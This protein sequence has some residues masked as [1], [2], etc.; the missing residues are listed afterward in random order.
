MT[1]WVYIL[2]NRCQG[3]I[4]VGVTSD[5]V[6]RVWQH[7]NGEVP[8]HTQRY[9]I[10]RLVHHEAFSE[11]HLAIR[12]EKSLKRWK[13]AWKDELIEATNPEWRDLWDEIAHP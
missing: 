12:R 13:R 5:L 8:G 11:A 3:A 6:R 10:K 2:A 4:Y 1:Y 7:R 9:S